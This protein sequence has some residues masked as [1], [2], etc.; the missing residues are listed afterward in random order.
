M[1]IIKKASKSHFFYNNLDLL[2]NQIKS[3]EKVNLKDV[4]DL[5][6]T[7]FI[8]KKTDN[9]SKTGGLPKLMDKYGIGIMGQSSINKQE[10]ETKKKKTD[11]DEQLIDLALNVHS[12]NYT[13]VKNKNKKVNFN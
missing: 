9:K 1:N 2:L 7:N 13:F 3:F 6:T 8:A 11:E 4:V 10:F 5:P 12:K